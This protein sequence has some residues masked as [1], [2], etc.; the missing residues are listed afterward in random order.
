MTIE[1]AIALIEN[2]NF[3]KDEPQRWAD[4]GCGSGIF[5]RALAFLLPPKSS[6]LC[7]DKREQNFKPTPGEDVQLTFRKGDFIK[8]ALPYAELDGIMM[9][10]SLHYVKDKARLIQKLR[11][12]LTTDGRF[13]IVEYDTEQSNLWVPYPIAFR[14]L[15]TLF[16]GWAAH[17]LGFTQVRKVGE[18]KSLYG[19]KSM[20]ACVVNL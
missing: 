2:A 14:N 8:E 15:E 10:N 6:V 11:P 1:E 18:R 19:A 20:Y 13:I 9:A 12:H 7:I 4:L 16:S 5:S 3:R 17:R